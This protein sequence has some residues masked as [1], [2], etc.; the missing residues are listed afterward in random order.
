MHKKTFELANPQLKVTIEAD[1]LQVFDHCTS[2][3]DELARTLT[4]HFAGPSQKEIF[5]RDH[6][7]NEAAMAKLKTLAKE[8]PSEATEPVQLTE[9][10]VQID[11][12]EAIAAS[13]VSD[14]VA[15]EIEAVPFEDVVQPFSEG[16][17]SVK[18]RGRPKGSKNK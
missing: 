5:Q 15:E 17:P 12:E 3:W 10:P 14:E 7:E 1:D 6:D 11:L 16:M 9:E 2:N 18:K 13:E 4:G 8:E